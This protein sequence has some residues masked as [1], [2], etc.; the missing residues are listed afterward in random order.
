MVMAPA[1]AQRHLALERANAVRSAAGELKREMKAGRV[2]LGDALV[3]ER[4]RSIKAFDLLVSQPR[5]ARVKASRHLARCGIPGH[6]RVGVLTDRQRRLLA[7]E[8]PA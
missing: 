8:G 2:S 7:G 6:R 5:W 1:M 3:D 4:A